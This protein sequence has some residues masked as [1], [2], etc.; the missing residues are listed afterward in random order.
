MENAIL[1]HEQALAL[2]ARAQAGDEQAREQ[3]IDEIIK[4]I[5]K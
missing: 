5:D 1:T 4:L 3:K 2:I